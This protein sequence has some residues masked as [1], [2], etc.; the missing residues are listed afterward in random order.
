VS[1]VERRR[2]VGPGE[3]DDAERLSESSS[4]AP[5]APLGGQ[6]GSASGGYGT[7]SADGTSGGTGAGDDDT[8]APGVDPQTDWLR[9]A[10]GGGGEA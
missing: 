6:A 2:N 7:G 5:S 10:P 3:V 8:S 1:E 9:D 4:V